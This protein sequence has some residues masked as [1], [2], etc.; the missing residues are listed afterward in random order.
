MQ[1][2]RKA[3]D[4]PSAAFA[5][6][7]IGPVP[8]AESV[9]DEYI[10]FALRWQPAVPPRIWLMVRNGSGTLLE[11][12]FDPSSRQ[13]RDVTLVTLRKDEGPAPGDPPAEVPV[14]EGLPRCEPAAWL[15]RTRTGSFNGHAD[16][17]L[18]IIAPVRLAFTSAGAMLYIDGI[19]G[20][21]AMELASGRARIG[22]DARGAIAYVRLTELT[23]R[24]AALLQEHRARP[25]PEVQQRPS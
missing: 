24:E 23:A 8:A 11:L 19:A 20:P 14:M 5:E 21:V 25:V 18:D 2:G 6:P 16:F 3:L 22:V 12:A 4:D 17:Y 7:F 13:L 1:P 10:P 15:A 9:G